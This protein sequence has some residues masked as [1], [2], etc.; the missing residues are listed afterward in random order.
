MQVL[1]VLLA[2]VAVLVSG[3][4]EGRLWRAGRISQRTI[5]ILVLARLPILVFLIGLILGEPDPLLL[6][7]LALAVLPAALMYGI[8]LRLVWDQAQEPPLTSVHEGS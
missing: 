8:M 3:R 4:I 1:L 5:T 6:P 2:I 7:I